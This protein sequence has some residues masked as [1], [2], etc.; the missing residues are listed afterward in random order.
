MDEVLPVLVSGI[1]Q[2]VPIFVIA[3]GLTLIYGVL[4]VLNF[5]HGA[6]FMIGAYVL[7][8][9]LNSTSLA[10]FVGVCL[11]AALVV[12]A[13]GWASEAVVFTWLYRSGSQISFLGAFAA[14]LV[15]QG[16][17]VVVWGNSPR[18]AAYPKSLQGSVT[19]AGARISVYD[20]AIVGVGVVVALGLYLLINRTSLGL[21]MRAVS[22]DRTMASALGVRS[23]RI[24]TTV[25]V[26]G[27]FLAGL[28]GALTAPITS[29]D[30][31]L[32][33]SFIVPAFVVVIVGGLGS[34]EG[35]LVAALL[36][37]VLESV[38][39][40]YAN[41]LSGFSYYIIVALILMVRPQGLFG[42]FSSSTRIAR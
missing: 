10:A 2:G 30:P 9:Q 12:M 26:I 14:F 28:A 40:R 4:H 11:V 18:T 27:S 15:L 38:L 31:S 8:T 20:L 24:A 35:A 23:R 1:A 5:A 19:V 41:W 17:V 34:V 37:G 22:H 36:L 39:F 29:V 13:V 32:A 7:A 16:L 25:F 42:S 21:Q 6:F 33:V 3:S